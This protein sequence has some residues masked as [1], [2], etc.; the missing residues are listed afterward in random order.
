MRSGSTRS[1]AHGRTHSPPGDCLF[2][3][4]CAALRS[5]G[6]TFKRSQSA[7]S[8]MFTEKQ[9]QLIAIRN[10]LLALMDAEELD[11]YPVVLHLEDLID[12]LQP[13]AQ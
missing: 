11:T 13:M 6:R 10:Q 12:D 7:F 4:G 1:I 2:E 9:K 5:Q 8:K 3:S